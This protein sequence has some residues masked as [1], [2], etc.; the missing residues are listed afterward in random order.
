MCGYSCKRVSS[1]PELFK[2]RWGSCGIFKYVF[3]NI[4]RKKRIDF[5]VLTL[6][7]EQKPPNSNTLPVLQVEKPDYIRY[8][9]FLGEE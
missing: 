8:Y 1:N 7:I 2:R 5:N 6:K 9:C 3:K 4:D